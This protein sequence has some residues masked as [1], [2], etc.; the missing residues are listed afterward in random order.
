M[1]HGMNEFWNGAAGVM[2]V[3]RN[4]VWVLSS[5]LFK[6]GPP[7]VRGK[8]PTVFKVRISTAELDHS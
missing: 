7:F 2:L 4:C 6:T 1:N 5:F 3:L 8:N